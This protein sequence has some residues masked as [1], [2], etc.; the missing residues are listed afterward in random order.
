V[1]YAK[2]P[3]VKVDKG[4]AILVMVSADE[5]TDVDFPAGGIGK[6]SLPKGV[7]G[8]CVAYDVPGKY[9][10]VIGEIAVMFIAVE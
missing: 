6:V 10:V 4:E 1:A 2:D 9:P 7:A 8:I 3:I 5:A